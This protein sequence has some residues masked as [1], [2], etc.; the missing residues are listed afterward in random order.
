MKREIA[1]IA[2]A[3]LAAGV[4]ILIFVIIS[5]WTVIESAFLQYILRMATG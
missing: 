3:L 5:A 4:V 1:L 2:Y